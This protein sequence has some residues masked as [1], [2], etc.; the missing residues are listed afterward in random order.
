[1]HKAEVE[2]ALTQLRDWH[3]EVAVVLG[4]GLRTAVIEEQTADT[5]PYSRFSDLPQISVPGHLGQFVL[6]QVGDTHII[7][8]QGRV[9]LYEG[10]S[11][12]E[13]TAFVR[14]LARAGVKTLILTNAAGSLNPSFTVGEWMMIKDHINLTGAS[15]LTGS[16]EFVDM[17][18]PYSPRLRTVFAQAAYNL[19]IVLREGVYAGL[20]GPQ[21]ETAAEVRMLQTIGA[22]AVGMSTVLEV[23]QAR[24]LGLEVA[25]FSCLTNMAAGISPRRLTHDDVL[26]T[27]RTAADVLG[28]L[29]TAALPKL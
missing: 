6:G 22:D 19:G 10:R 11:P 23:I 2:R 24:A 25:G 16:P 8:A 12:Y 9:H 26:E 27:G 13:L 5:I 17:S 21:Y 29:L 3:A 15:P 1:M 18:E 4:S 28:R 7:F 20:I 14:T